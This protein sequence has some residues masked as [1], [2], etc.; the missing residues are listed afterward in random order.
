M[1][2]RSGAHR[3]R[4]VNRLLGE[5]G[6]GLGDTVAMLT[7]GRFSGATR[8]LM[9]GH[10]APEAAAGGPIAF[11]REGDMISIDI[12][13]RRLDVEVDA[14]EMA[15]RA[16]GWEKPAPRY[17]HGVFAKYALQVSSAA[18]GAVTS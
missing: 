18:I 11:I 13:A 17:K 3:R 16:V 14:A 9:A 12:T 10:V 2:F 5:L 4:F 1:L 8:G 6:V 15:T 7:D